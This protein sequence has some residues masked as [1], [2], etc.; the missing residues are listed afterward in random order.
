[1]EEKYKIHSFYILL[2]LCSIIV[3]LIS[4]KWAEIPQLVN[5]ITFALT[6]S[7]LGL[8]LLAIIYSMYSNTAFS[9]NISTLESNTN[10]LTTTSTKLSL[11]TEELQAKMEHIPGIIKTVGEKVEA[12]HALVTDLKTRSSLDTDSSQSN[13]DLTMTTEIPESIL[14]AFLIR[15]S[16]N[17]LLTLYIYSLSLKTN[18]PFSYD[19][20]LEMV[21][22]KKD[23][24]FAYSVAVRAAG[25]LNYQDK[26][27]IWVI[28]DMNDYLSDQ[29]SKK[30][31]E[32]IEFI[33]KN[34]TNEKFKSDLQELKKKVTN[35]FYPKT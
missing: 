26:N 17:G 3:G 35:H 1:M 22:L 9:Q 29:V 2:I 4:V 30:L 21:D 5:Y 23:Y 13:T 8:A 15:S 32:K 12:T 16:F 28:E 18:T 24:S 27:D 20:V 34:E 25:L 7:S 19:D 10:T 11:A 31:D 33:V 6:V 14:S